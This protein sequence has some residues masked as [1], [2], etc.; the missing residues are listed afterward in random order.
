MRQN[1]RSAPFKGPV[2]L[3]R[4]SLLI[5]WPSCLTNYR[6]VVDLKDA[7]KKEDNTFSGVCDYNWCAS[8]YPI[9]CNVQ[10]IWIAKLFRRTQIW[11]S[12]RL[13]RV[14]LMS[15]RWR[16]KGLCY[17]WDIVASYDRAWV[18]VCITRVSV[19]GRRR[20]LPV[21][22]LKEPLVFTQYRRPC[23]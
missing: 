19:T 3:N 11:T 6:V 23:W 5:A 12:F 20:N 13:F 9:Q 16:S 15:D 1:H 22:T 4:D 2:L 8:C 18:K 7:K 21:L 17:M 14:G 10:Y